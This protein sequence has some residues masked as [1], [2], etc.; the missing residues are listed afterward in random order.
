LR[1]KKLS[2]TSD[3]WH[4]AVEHRRILQN[5][6]AAEDRGGRDFVNGTFDH[7]TVVLIDAKGCAKVEQKIGGTFQKPAVD[8]PNFLVAQA[9]P[10][11]KLLK[12]GRDILPGGEVVPWWKFTAQGKQMLAEVTTAKAKRL[13]S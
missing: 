1:N 2:P 13:R 11:L 6:L 12:K 3:G 5:P 4:P 8:K 10:A 9:G 7:V